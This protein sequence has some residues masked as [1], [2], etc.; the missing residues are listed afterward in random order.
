M[1]TLILFKYIMIG[2]I[3]NPFLKK[4]KDRITIICLKLCLISLSH[5]NKMVW[6]L[7]YKI[8]KIQLFIKMIIFIKENLHKAKIYPKKIVSFDKIEEVLMENNLK[9]NFYKNKISLMNLIS[10]LSF[11]FYFKLIK[12]SIITH[13]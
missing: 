11:S 6:I 5:K 10:A 8:A 1:K 13:I 9:L 4:L 7:I 2:K 3:I 12:S